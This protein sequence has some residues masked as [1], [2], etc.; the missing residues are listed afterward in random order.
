MTTLSVYPDALVSIT[1]L[2]GPIGSVEDWVVTTDFF[3]MKKGSIALFWPDKL[4]IFASEVIERTRNVA[5]ILDKGSVEIAKTQEALYI[6]DCLRSGPFRDSLDF[7]GIHLDQ[8]I[9]NEYTQ[10]FDFSLMELAFLQFKE[11]VKLL[12]F[13]EDVINT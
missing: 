6:L 5:E 10:I 9:A 7:N 13:V 11:E 1:K 4:F 2:F 8:A 3:E 12:Q